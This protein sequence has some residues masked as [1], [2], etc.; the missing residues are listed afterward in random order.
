[1]L[2]IILIWDQTSVKH[3]FVKTHPACLAC[4][5]GSA[6]WLGETDLVDETAGKAPLS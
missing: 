5:N 6:G 4:R 2:D 1:M 3:F